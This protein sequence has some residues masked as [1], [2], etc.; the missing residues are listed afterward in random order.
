MFLYQIKYA[1]CLCL[2]SI[3]TNSHRT[4]ARTFTLTKVHGSKIVF[5]CHR[6]KTTSNY[7]AILWKVIDK[8]KVRSRYAK[9]AFVYVK[10]ESRCR[11]VCVRGRACEGLAQVWRQGWSRRRGLAGG[12]AA[13][14]LKTAPC[15]LSS[16][17]GTLR[18]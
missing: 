10:R 15:K 14:L 17:P 1:I 7:V 3:N 8:N 4:F 13:A 16:I 2:Q 12:P 9:C 18:M 11:S 6:V 5:Q